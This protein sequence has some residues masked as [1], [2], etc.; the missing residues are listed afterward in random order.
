VSLRGAGTVG[1]DFPGWEDEL[2]EVGA[3]DRSS[4]VGDSASETVSSS[5]SASQG[6]L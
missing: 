5:M 2:G 1:G 3:L 6:T 4:D